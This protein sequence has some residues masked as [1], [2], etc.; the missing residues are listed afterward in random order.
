M[1]LA[2]V[3]A[4]AA[5]P[6][7]A[8]TRDAG[9]AQMDYTKIAGLSQPQYSPRRARM[10]LPSSD[11]TKLDIEVIR[12]NAPGRFPVILEASPYHGQPLVSD[13]RDGTDVIP[14]QGLTGWFV[15]R[16]YV[17]IIM[18][19][20]GTG[21]SRGCLDFFGPDDARDLTQV[22]NWSASQEWSNGR[23]GMTGVSYVGS[24]PI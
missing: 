16:G 21:A 24:T 4:L 15:P 11:G 17:V 20:R 9:S 19:M 23:V 1:I 8:R 2:L 12:P 13:D 7:D 6:A 18:A 3:A 22:I 14:G 10:T 5:A